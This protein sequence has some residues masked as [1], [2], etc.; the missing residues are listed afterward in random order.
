LVR[1]SSC[2]TSTKKLVFVA[3]LYVKCCELRMSS[4]VVNASQKIPLHSVRQVIAGC[5][6]TRGFNCMEPVVA[7]REV[8]NRH[9]RYRGSMD[10]QTSSKRAA[11]ALIRKRREG[12][13]VMCV[14]EA[15]D[16]VII[17]SRAPRGQS[18]NCYS[19]Y[20]SDALSRA[21]CWWSASAPTKTPPNPA[22]SKLISVDMLALTTSLFKCSTRY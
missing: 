4:L 7:M 2:K 11:E 20:Y 3:C 22:S 18:C 19:I 14:S 10:Q 1:L 9:A 17:L 16:R 8:A 5:G 13:R 15:R 12:D 6:S 21:W